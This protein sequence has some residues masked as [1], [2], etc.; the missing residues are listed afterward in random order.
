MESAAAWIAARMREYVAQRQMLPLI[1][2]LMS[3]SLGVE[4]DSSNAVADMICPD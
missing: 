2:L 3:A 4:F 1:A